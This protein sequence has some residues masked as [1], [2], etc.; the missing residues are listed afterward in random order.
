[1]TP[2][3]LM[4]DLSEGDREAWSADRRPRSICLAASSLSGT[5]IS[6]FAILCLISCASTRNALTRG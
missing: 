4:T 3:A 2:V 6:P 5:S 1:M